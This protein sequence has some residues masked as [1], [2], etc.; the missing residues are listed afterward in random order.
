MIGKYVKQQGYI[1]CL[2]NICY[3]YI[4]NNM[5]KIGQTKHINNRLSSYNSIFIDK[6]E[7]K[8]LINVNDKQ[9]AETIIFIKL[10]KYRILESRELFICD[11]EIIKKVFDETK[12]LLDKEEDE[13]NNEAILNYLEID[14][15]EIKKN[16]IYECLI[17]KLN[18]ILFNGIENKK[19]YFYENKK[20]DKL[21]T[22]GNIDTI[23]KINYDDKPVNADYYFDQMPYMILQYLNI[24]TN[25]SLDIKNYKINKLEKIKN[26]NKNNGKIS[27]IQPFEFNYYNKDIYKIVFGLK[28]AKRNLCTPFIYLKVREIYTSDMGKS[29]IL[30]NNLL[31]DNKF[32]DNYFIIDDI[33][34]FIERINYIK[35][36]NI[37]KYVESDNVIE[38]NKIEII[39]NE[40]YKNKKKS[41][42][43]FIDT[44]Y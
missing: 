27:F 5:Y 22:F 21:L 37:I 18:S 29:Y 31:K 25:N 8:Y 12:L 43:I 1:Y 11:L 9:L 35:K 19:K 17:E 2:Y 10:K 15:N 14:K 23:Y 13:G 28:K 6:C 39:S 44:N 3:S 32:C 20:I 34:N 4:S 26:I 38:N 7:Y 40:Q 42:G 16:T 30:I 41:K 24:R 36:N 33:D